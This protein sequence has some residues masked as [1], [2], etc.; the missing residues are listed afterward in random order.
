[1]TSRAPPT[2]GYTLT[3]LVVAVSLSMVACLGGL[4]AVQVAGGLERDAEGAKA[5]VEAVRHLEARVASTGPKRCA[6][7]RVL[8]PAAPDRGCDALW[9]DPAFREGRA[10]TRAGQV[11][12][13][14]RVTYVLTWEPVAG[15]EGVARA[16]VELRVDGELEVR[17]GLLVVIP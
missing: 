11:Q 10:V 6:L 7:E 13:S 2:R 15:Q 5:C 12:R 8:D 14:P 17:H 9:A 16:L 1:M 3:E 4:Q